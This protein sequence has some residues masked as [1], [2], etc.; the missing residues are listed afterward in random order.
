MDVALILRAPD[1]TG[2]EI[3][4]EIGVRGCEAAVPYRHDRRPAPPHGVNGGAEPP[5]GTF[6]VSIDSPRPATPADL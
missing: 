5:Q 2:L 6:K 4:D 1:G 3:D